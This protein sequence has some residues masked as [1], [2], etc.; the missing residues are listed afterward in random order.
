MAYL[1]CHECG[2][3][4]DDFWEWKIK[5]K[6]IFKWQTRPFGYNPISLMLEDIAEYW[7]PRYIG[8]DSYWCKEHGLKGNKVHSWWLLRY[9]LKRHIKRL[10]S[11]KYW[12]LNSYKK[13]KNKG[14]AVCPKCGSKND[15]DID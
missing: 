6:N 1:H 11:M 7:K 3:F 8:M 2:W 15:F 12:T 4:Q 10:F 9:E 5:W 13:A 14:I